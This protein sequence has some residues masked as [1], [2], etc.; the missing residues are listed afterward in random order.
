M[1]W[2]LL[3]NVVAAKGAARDRH[4]R[5]EPRQNAAVDALA[6]LSQMASTIPLNDLRAAELRVEDSGVVSLPRPKEL[7]L[8]IRT[9]LAHPFLRTRTGTHMAEMAAPTP[10]KRK[11][12]ISPSPP[13]SPS[14][15]DDA[16]ACAG[17]K[18]PAPRQWPD[19]PELTAMPCGR[20][21][22]VCKDVHCPQ[23]WSNRVASDARMM[24]M[25]TGTW[26]E[27]IGCS[28]NSTLQKTWQ[29]P[30]GHANHRWQTRGCNS[31]RS[32]PFPCCSPC[33]ARRCSDFSC[34]VCLH[35]SVASD[36]HRMKYWAGTRSQALQTSKG[37]TSLCLWRCPQSGHEWKAPSEHASKWN[38]CG[39]A[40]CS[41]RP[42]RLCG[43]SSC[44]TCL[45]RTVAG[46]EHAMRFWSGSNAD[47]LMTFQNSSKPVL[48]RCRQGGHEWMQS[49]NV[50]CGQR[51]GCPFPCCCASPRRL[52][53]KQDCRC[54]LAASVAGSEHMMQFW[55]NSVQDA[56]LTSRASGKRVHWRCPK[57]VCQHV[58]E[59]NVY[60]FA[61]GENGCPRCALV[62]GEK[63]VLHFLKAA[64]IDHVHQW[65]CSSCRVVRPLPFDFMISV[66][67]ECLLEID[68]MQHFEA[69]LKNSESQGNFVQRR[70][71]D[72]KKITWAAS[73]CKPM[74][75]V[76]T[77]AI[78][79]FKPQTWQ[80]WLQS[81]VADHVVPSAGKP[82]IVLEDCPRYRTMF[83]ECL[84]DD[85]ALGPHVVFHPMG[86][87]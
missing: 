69:V 11:R 14:L 86:S 5:L 74:I 62:E 16:V 70:Q 46:D 60:N 48:W 36:E 34:E 37:C 13:P 9:I 51:V 44:G 3:A 19:P 30:L 29:C 47:A 49:P 52:C 10:C 21:A 59:A 82:V 63:L 84:R 20:R 38:T 50:V 77:R 31:V 25:W 80:S 2:C 56:M 24:S 45:P 58:W 73:N 67:V 65:A 68:G 7:V 12:P 26:N 78:R 27:A 40:C 23:C 18:R 57:R 55:M 43:L 22:G 35:W 87:S 75:R 42:S 72:L 85:P 71:I 1:R 33:A 8:A 15:D 6:T 17:L 4:S 76:T 66:Q 61:S 53:G 28:K 54:C 32:C 83:A 81:A 79:F 41:D 64:R 39:F